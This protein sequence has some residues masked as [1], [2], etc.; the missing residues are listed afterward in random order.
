MQGLF[1]STLR[2]PYNRDGYVRHVL[3]MSKARHHIHGPG[4]IWGV[5][6]HC[7]P[8]HRDTAQGQTRPAGAPARRQIRLISRGALSLLALLLFILSA[9]AT[10]QSTGQ[11]MAKN[12]VFVWPFQK[13]I[14][15]INHGE[16]FDPAVIA[17]TYDMTTASMIYSG[18]VTFSPTMQVVP[19]AATFTVDSSGK[20]YT[21]HLRANLRFSDG[22]PIT[23][24]DYA[25]SIDRALDPSLCAT[26]DAQTYGPPATAPGQ[27]GG[28]GTCNW[29]SGSAPLAASYLSYIV[30]ARDRYSGKIASL[31]GTGD[32]TT[33]GLDVVDDRTLRIRLT[34]PIAFFLQ[35]LTYP[36]SWPVERSLVQKYPGGLWVDHLNEGGCSGPFKIASYGGGKELKLVPNTYWE[37][38]WGKKLHL[39]EVDRPLVRKMDDEYQAY[40]AGQY[41]YTDIPGQEYSLAR[42]QEDFHEIATLKERYFGLNFDKP[43][44]DNQLVRQAFDLS[45]NKQFLVDSIYRGGAEPTNHIVPRGMIGYNADLRNPPPDGTQSLTGN[46]NAAKSLLK[47]ALQ[48][49]QAQTLEQPDYC[50]Y[51]DAGS[52]SKEIDVWYPASNTTT[53]QV[54]IRA[55]SAWNSILNLNIKAKGE[56]DDNTFFGSLAIHSPYQAWS[57]GWIA[58]YPD[59]QDWLSLQFLSNSQNNGSDVQDANLDKLMRAA[60]IEQNPATRIHDYNQIEQYVVNLCAWIPYAQEKTYWRQRSWVQGFTLNPLQVMVDIAWPNVYITAH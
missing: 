1:D 54:A 15:Q 53:T 18:L 44:F 34:A 40:R 52:N 57:V 19:D 45:L 21:F 7:M 12:Q 31:I 3:L 41:D 46:Q 13:A 27:A 59:P 22:T 39:T 20:V 9:C 43:P 35:A 4:T 26:Q 14:D 42:D 2:L 37:D 25:Y 6:G 56:P 10:T 16:V 5:E 60:D 28:T 29:T 36:V 32:D 48:T 51:I 58:D 33:H 30:G 55:V 24:A 17:T 23:A 50:P 49:C 8:S 47:S 11:T 38:A